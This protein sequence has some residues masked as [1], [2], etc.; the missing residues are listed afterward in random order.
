MARRRHLLP[1]HPSVRRVTNINLS[2]NRSVSP[3]SRTA[4][5]R[6]LHRTLKYLFSKTPR[7]CR[8]GRL[9]STPPFDTDLN[10]LRIWAQFPEFRKFLRH[11]KNS[12]YLFILI[13]LSWHGTCSKASSSIFV[14]YRRLTPPA[15]WPAETTNPAQ[16]GR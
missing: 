7:I 3:A 4:K 14:E 11:R 15:A 16:T 1:D 12:T 9:T 13:I 10:F 8:I 6:L 2:P 5:Y